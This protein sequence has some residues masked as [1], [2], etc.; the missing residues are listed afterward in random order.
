MSFEKKNN[1]SG[2]LML[3][4]TALIWGTAF[5][6]QSSAMDNIGPLLF[7]NV[8]FF[9]G[10]LVLIPFIWYFGHRDRMQ[11]KMSAKIHRKILIDSIIPGIFCGIF[12]GIATLFQQYGI[13]TTTAG[14]SAF[15]TALYIVFVPIAEIFLGKSIHKSI[16]ISIFLA[17][18]GFWLLCIKD[19]FSIS[20]GDILTLACAIFFTGQILCIDYVMKKNVDPIMTSCVEFFT[21]SVMT[22]IPMLIF[23]G[24]EL[25]KIYLALPSILYTGIFSAGVAYTLQMVAQRKTEPALAT[26]I[27][28]LESVFAALAGW[29]IL[30]E[31]MSIREFSGCVLV[32]VAVILAQFGPLIN[33]HGKDPQTT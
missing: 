18:I 4:A 5:V 32:L 26:L 31:A 13:I 28:S 1:I 29:I 24:F 8:R 3:L 11:G 17:I 23:E 30:G 27:M 9:L 7:V 2:S 22:L 16:I 21:V 14:K 15:I 25:D 12:L 10:G 33:S 6:A 20:H 19:D